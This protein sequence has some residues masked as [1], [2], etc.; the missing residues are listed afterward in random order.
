MQDA[1]ANILKGDIINLQGRF[2]P[3]NLSA[4]VFEGTDPESVQ[5]YVENT[6]NN[7]GAVAAFGGYNEKRNL[8]SDKDLFSSDESRRR[9]IHL[10]LDIWAPAGTGVIAPLDA[11][12]HS[13][14]FNPGKGNYGPTIIL[15]HKVKS[16]TFFTLYGHLSAESIE[17][18]E[19]G[20]TISKGA[21]F[22]YLG[23][24]SINGGYAPHLHFQVIVDI[25]EHFGDYPGVCA[26][27]DREAFLKN[28]PNPELLINI[29]L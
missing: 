2:V 21:E 8:Y 5:A 22:A 24:S 12:V 7:A 13:F 20:E 19:I 28:C 18:I 6:T 16:G 27:S 10:G 4:S 11:T 29:P 14:D 23:D 3:I 25:G 17:D 26:Q 15:E 1:F 9:D